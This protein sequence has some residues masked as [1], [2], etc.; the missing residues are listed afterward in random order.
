MNSLPEAERAR[1]FQTAS[2][3]ENINKR[4]LGVKWDVTKDVFTFDTVKV[5]EEDVTKR[6]ILKTVASIFD[7][8]GFVA[9]FLVTGKIFLQKLWRLKVY[10]DDKI[11]KSQYKQWEKWK[12]DLVNLKGVTIPRSHHPSRYLAK[13]MQLHVLCEKCPNTELFLVRIFLYSD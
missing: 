8:V 5:K 10:W 11:T 13:D 4:T 2:F 1:S 6:N 7:P 9:P 3:N 12:G